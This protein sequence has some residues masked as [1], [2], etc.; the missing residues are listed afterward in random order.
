MTKSFQI[1]GRRWTSKFKKLKR[2]QL[3]W[4]QKSPHKDN[5]PAVRSQRRKQSW[6]QQHK[7]QL[8]TYNGVHEIISVHKIIS[9]F[10][11][12]NV[13][14]QKGVERYNLKCWKKKKLAKKKKKHLPTKTFLAELSFKNGREV[15]TI[16]DKQRL[17]EI[18][19]TAL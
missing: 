11:S 4:T 5:D 3:E 13:S 16:P 9:R 18:I 19:F 17:K 7:N 2:F 12:R 14:G 6:K 8:V 1:W 15:R 10:L